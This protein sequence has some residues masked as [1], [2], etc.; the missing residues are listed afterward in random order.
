M[1]GS[2]S[3]PKHPDDAEKRR[4]D[5]AMVRNAWAGVHDADIAAVLVDAKRGL[6]EEADAI[7]DGL[8]LP[9][10]EGL[11]L[12]ASRVAPLLADPTAL[13]LQEEAIARYRE[14]PPD[15]VVAL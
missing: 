9:L 4:L 6:D 11:A 15:E 5:R 10:E 3:D 13:E 12:E 1:T 7:L 8:A 2:R 14:T